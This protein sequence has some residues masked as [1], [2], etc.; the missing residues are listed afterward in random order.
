MKAK[1]VSRPFRFLALRKSTAVFTYPMHILAFY[2]VAIREQTLQY[3]IARGHSAPQGNGLLNT[4]GSPGGHV[5]GK[6]GSLPQLIPCN[7]RA[8]HL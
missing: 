6:T 5:P 7:P 8:L 1:K 4:R 3:E 2:G